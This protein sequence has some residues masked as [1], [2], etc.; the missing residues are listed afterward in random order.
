MKDQDQKQHPGR[1]DVK[2]DRQK[3]GWATAVSRCA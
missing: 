3:N 1:F 2:S